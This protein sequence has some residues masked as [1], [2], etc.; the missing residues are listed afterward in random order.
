MAT[1]QVILV[2]LIVALTCVHAQ[3]FDPYLWQSFQNLVNYVQDLVAQIQDLFV[4]NAL[5]K[6]EKY[7]REHRQGV[8]YDETIKL[9]TW[10]MNRNTRNLDNSS[11]PRQNYFSDD[12]FGI[13]N[14]NILNASGLVNEEYWERVS[15]KAFF[16]PQST[17]PFVYNVVIDGFILT[18]FT[19]STD[20]RV[21]GLQ[22]ALQYF[23]QSSQYD[24][25]RQPRNE[26]TQD[27]FFYWTLDF[28][29]KIQRYDCQAE[30][31]QWHVEASG[32]NWSD[33]V[34]KS[35]TMNLI[36]QRAMTYCNDTGLSN[37]TQYASFED[38]MD[39]LESKYFSNGDAAAGD[40][41]WCRLIHSQMLDAD[42]PVGANI[43]CP[44]VG[45]SGGGECVEFTPTMYASVH[46]DKS[47]V[48]FTPIPTKATL[49][50]RGP[51]FLL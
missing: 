15:A 1:K 41:V 39:F 26:L 46:A 13:Y 48:P 44:H 43:H 24:P 30:N 38:C 32:R 11:F 10:I 22:V 17:Y 9:Y 23:N 49:Q 5:L 20:L 27:C 12:V 51:T 19:Y 34:F 14:P 47:P 18:H 31:V 4:Q 7:D 42:F 37:N 50:T 3:G 2:F 35:G 29:P 25:Q 28:P 45:P 21:T 36:C 40:N 16:Y 6:A 33:P 8:L